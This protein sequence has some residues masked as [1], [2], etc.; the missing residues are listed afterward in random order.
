MVENFKHAFLHSVLFFVFDGDAAHQK[1][2]IFGRESFRNG[3]CDLLLRKVRKNIRDVEHG[4][5]FFVT[6]F[7]VNA[8][9]VFESDHTVKRKRNGE[10][11]ILFDTAVVMRLEVRHICLFI[12][13]NLFEIESGA[14][15]VS[16]E[17]TH[18][19]LCDVRFARSYD[20]QALA[21][22]VV[23]K[24]VAGIDFVAERIRLITLFLN[25]FDCF[26]D[27]FSFG[28]AVVEKSLVTLCIIAYCFELLLVRQSVDVLSFIGKIHKKPSFKNLF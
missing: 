13:R 2:E 3:L 1:I 23:I 28:F 11:L 9:A 25:H 26:L 17:N 20:K 6:D 21:A 8:R 18:A 16:D 7:D 19:V 15:D 24:L 27:G 12:K 14:I 22:I 10:P 5:A 4:I